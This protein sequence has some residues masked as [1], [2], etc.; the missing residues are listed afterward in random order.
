MADPAAVAA[1]REALS[2]PPVGAGVSVVINQVSGFAPNFTVDASA[3]VNAAVRMILADR[4]AP[5]AD[6]LGAAQP[7]AIEQGDRIVIV[8]ADDLT[9]AGFPR[10]MQRGDQVVLPNASEVLNVLRVDPY[11]RAFAGAIELTV[12]GVA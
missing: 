4:T 3:T 10:P 1:Y 5:A 12:V 8:M 2:P 6:G 7:G 9:A 11:K